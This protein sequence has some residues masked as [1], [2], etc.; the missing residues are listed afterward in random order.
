MRQRAA[1]CEHPFG[2]LKR[3]P[4]WDHVPVRGF[5]RVRGEMA[6]LVHC[7]NFR[8]LLRLCGVAG[9]IAL[10]RAHRDA[11]ADGDGRGVRVWVLARVLK[12]RREAIGGLA[13]C[14][15]QPDVAVG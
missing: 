6:L 7:C 9:F 2:T 15:R 14:F 8:R 4:G 13:A 3:R 5:A 1:L 12:R 11:G 10:C